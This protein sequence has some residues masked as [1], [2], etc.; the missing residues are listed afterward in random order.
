[1][2]K[3][4]QLERERA[5]IWT[6]V[7]LF[8]CRSEA[9]FQQEYYV[10]LCDWLEKVKNQKDEMISFS[11]YENGKAKRA[12][13]EVYKWLMLNRMITNFLRV[14]GWEIYFTLKVS[15]QIVLQ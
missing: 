8:D 3:V 15:L 13:V 12:M 6:Q 9:I 5:E 14:R 11:V 4:S 10:Q 2:P 7:D 1:M